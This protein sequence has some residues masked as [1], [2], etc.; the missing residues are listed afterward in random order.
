[1]GLELSTMKWWGWGDEKIQFD[2]DIR[3]A[4]W[5]YVQRVLKIG[6]DLPLRPAVPL[7]SIA[8]PAVKENAAFLAG[9]RTALPSEQIDSGKLARLTH[10]FGKSCRDLWRIR[11]GIV[12]YAPDIVVYPASHTE[13]RTLIDL[14]VRHGVHLIPFGGGSNVAGCLEPLAQDSRMV[15][16]LD[17]RR[18]DRVI[19]LDPESGT[20]CIEAGALGPR[21]EEQLGSH[22]FTL[23]HFPDSF[24]FSTVGGW[25]ATRSAG[26]Q[27]DRYG[28]I[29]D[30]VV[31][32]RMAT[33]AGDIRT[34]ELPRASNGIDV[35]RLCIGSEG[36]LGVITEVTLR[37]HPLPAKKTTRGYLFPDFESGLA[38]MLACQRENVVPVMMRLNDPQKTALSASFAKRQPAHQRLL[39]KSLR[40]YLRYIKRWNLDKTCLMLAG[41]EGSR[42]RCGAERRAAQKIFRR[43]GAVS[44]GESPGRSF[45]EGKFDFPYLRDYLFERDILCDVSETA[46]VWSRIVPLYQAVVAAVEQAFAAENT[47]GWVGCHVS[48][49]YHAGATL[50]FTFAWLAPGG[51]GQEQLQQFFRIKKAGL[52]AFLA[53]GATFSHH[54]AVGYEHMPWLERDVSTAGVAAIRAM[55]AGVDPANIMNAGRLAGGLSVEDWARVGLP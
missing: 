28:K 41:F 15:V 25:V 11:R 19:A 17:M 13:V 37:V 40:H 18:M 23:G 12:P 33:P 2:M 1:M 48:H 43:H 51:S 8:L 50:Y 47:T 34:Q 3:P 29:E 35:N 54:H 10:A 36:S 30:M 27:S 32:V 49:T 5:N 16:S 9:L 22:G 44:I 24:L 39:S 26:M 53:N 6:H 55:K 14:A 21:L 42:A 20:A 45:N 4:L 38:A 46:T 52:D 7:D 31:S